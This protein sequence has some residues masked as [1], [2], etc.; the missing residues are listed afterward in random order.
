MSVSVGLTLKDL[1]FLGNAAPSNSEAVAWAAKV[2]ANGGAS[3]SAG[4]VSALSTFMNTLVSKSLRTKLFLLNI[5]APDSLTAAITPVVSGNGSNPWQNQNFLSGDLTVNGL[6]G[7][8]TTKGLRTG[9]NL[10]LGGTSPATNNNA[11]FT[12]YCKSIPASDNFQV[13]AYDGSAFFGCRVRFNDLTCK[14]TICDN[15][16]YVGPATFPGNGLFAI[17]RVSSTDQRMF[18]GNSTNVPAQ[19]GTTVAAGNA[20][21]MPNAQLGMF[22]LDGSS[23]WS[24]G[25]LSF[26]AAHSGMSLSEFTDFFTAIQALRTALGGGFV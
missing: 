16:N 26:F 1:A 25:T 17:N 3:P 15:N 2:V 8:G 19:I 21:N 13:G 23:G 12:V 6:T 14:G 11:G 7:N 22:S 4:T 5:I 10:N 9:L 24:S 18:W 20:F